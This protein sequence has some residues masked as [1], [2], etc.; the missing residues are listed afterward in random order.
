MFSAQ[1]LSDSC[2]D[3]PH[4]CGSHTNFCCSNDDVY[5]EYYKHLCNNKK[6]LGITISPDE[7]WFNSTDPNKQWDQLWNMLLRHCPKVFKHYVFTCG[8]TKRGNI[9]VHGAFTIRDT[10]KYYGF[11]L[12]KAKRLGIPKFAVK[13]NSQD[14]LDEKWLE[15]IYDNHNQCKDVIT[16]LPVIFTSTSDYV[17]VR[18]LAT[19][20]RIYRLNKKKRVERPNIY[21]LFGLDE[22]SDDESIN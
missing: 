8:M 19:Y 7:K 9:H 6:S 10:K 4:L 1:D 13:F 14:K 17:Y 22:P 5:D 20:S 16:D 12:P 18:K 21:T 3:E 2:S 11:W 15:Y